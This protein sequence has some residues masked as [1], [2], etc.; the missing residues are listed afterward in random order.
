MQF[1]LG[2][3]QLNSGYKSLRCAKKGTFQSQINGKI[4]YVLFHIQFL[5]F[6][7][8]SGSTFDGFKM[9]CF[10]FEKNLQ[11]INLANALA[12]KKRLK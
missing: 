6:F 4:N 8:N 12:T 11:P 9:H 1:F 3:F 2:I 7:I 10:Q 5:E